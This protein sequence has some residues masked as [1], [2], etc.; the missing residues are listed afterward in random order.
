MKTAILIASAIFLTS[1]LVSSYALADN[2]DRCTRNAVKFCNTFES[3]QGTENTRNG[4][5][6]VS[7]STGDHGARASRK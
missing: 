6:K 3:G 7:Q 2:Y 1:T 4:A 5:G